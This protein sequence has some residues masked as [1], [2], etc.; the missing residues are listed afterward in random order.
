MILG[1][2]FQMVRP[3]EKLV[4][5]AGL[6]VVVVDGGNAPEIEA[7]SYSINEGF[8]TSIAIGRVIEA[9]TSTTGVR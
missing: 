7:N 6:R 1:I 5:R 3:A 2:R 9:S 4:L 8:D